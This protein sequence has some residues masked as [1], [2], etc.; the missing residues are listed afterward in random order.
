[1]FSVVDKLNLLSRDLAQVW[2]VAL[3][4]TTIVAK[5][6]KCSDNLFVVSWGCGSWVLKREPSRTH[7]DQDMPFPNLN[8]LGIVI[9]T[10]NVGQI[11]SP[12]SIK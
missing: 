4:I 10:N 11:T 2:V 3:V 8:F 6:Q 7:F 1:M 9:L 12:A 5:T